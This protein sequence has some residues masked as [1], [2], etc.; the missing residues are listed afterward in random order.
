M[1]S[2]A[3]KARDSEIGQVK[4]TTSEETGITIN[5]PPVKFEKRMT[6]TIEQDVDAP[7]ETLETPNPISRSRKRE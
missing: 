5:I 2:E 4:R 3:R 7:R 1:H 6:Q